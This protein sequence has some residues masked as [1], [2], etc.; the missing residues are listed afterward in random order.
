MSNRIYFLCC[1][2]LL[3]VGALL[4][5][6]GQAQPSTTRYWVQLRD[7]KGV[8]FNP[9][10]YFT[11]AALAR[12][13][14]QQLPLA[15]S[16]DYPVRPVYLHAL[17]ATSDSVTMV[18]RWLNGAVCWATPA[19]VQALHRLPGVRSVLPLPEHQVQLATRAALGGASMQ[20]STTNRQLA[21][22]QTESLGAVQLRQAH[23]DGRGLRIAIFDA[24]FN[25]VDRHPA[26]EHLRSGQRIVATYDFIKRQPNVYHGANHGGEVLSCVAGALPD[27]SYLGLAS[28]A[29]FLLARTEQMFRER[30]AEEEAWLAAAE[31]ADR[32]GADIINSSLGYTKRRYFPEQMNGRT[33]LIAR[34][35]EMAVRKGILVV[36]AAGNDGEDEDWRTIGTP[37]DG[38]SVLTVGGLDPDTYLHSDFSSYGPGA[39]RRLK[40]NVAAFS[41]ALVAAPGGYERI[42]GTSFA[43]PLMVGLAACLWQ[44]QRQLTAMEVFRKLEKA[45]E[46]YPYYDYAHG[47]GRPQIAVLLAPASPPAAPTPTFD[48]VRRDTMVAVVVRVAAAT[49]PARTLPLYA[50]SVRAVTPAVRPNEVPALGKESTVPTPEA[51]AEEE[52]VPA[53]PPRYLYWHIANRQGVLRRYEVR[54]VTQRAVLEMPLRLL[55]PGDV[56][57]VHYRGST[58]TYTAAP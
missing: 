24:G 36:N 39:G 47:Y 38:D 22:R 52:P 11:P 4:P 58:Q 6:L 7:K 25:G 17:A 41:T 45:G 43:S 8:E 26:F 50:D 15:D 5:R 42:E 18:S 13:V 3:G 35:A 9:K 34:A 54:D 14:R 28:G 49:V 30:Y 12:R 27:G 33:S 44:Q 46:L 53:E 16:T 40:P 2:L 21:R 23:L 19:Q 48:F 37:A 32:Q 56:L 29:E 20:I 1:Q 31:W 10:A 55:Q 57:R 51:P